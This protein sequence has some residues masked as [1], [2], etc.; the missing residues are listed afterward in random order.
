VVEHYRPA[1]FRSFRNNEREAM[2]EYFAVTTVFRTRKAAI[3][4]S[5]RGRSNGNLFY[6]VYHMDRKPVKIIEI[7]VFDQGYSAE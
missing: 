5:L 7:R 2:R 4:F 6:V 1:A 3:K